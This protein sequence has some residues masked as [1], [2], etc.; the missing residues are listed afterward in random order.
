MT[1]TDRFRADLDALAAPGARLGIALSGGPDSLALLLLAAAAR[2]GAVEAA[3]VDH[4]LRTDS[5]AEAEAAAAICA[6][7]GIPHV[8]LTIDWPERPITALQERARGERYRLLAGWAE[9]RGL[10]AIL[11][12]HHA[13][14]QAET[15]LMRLNRG[16]GVRGLGGM[17]P[18]SP[19]PQVRHPRERG[20]PPVLL[21]PLLGWRRAE[22]ERICADANLT[23][24]TDPS[25]AD[26]RFERVRIR[27]ALSDAGWIDSSA[28]AT[29]AAHLASADQALDWA[30]DREWR[31]AVSEENGRITYMPSDAPA[32]I[33]RRLVAR[34]ITALT[35]EGSAEPLRARELDPLLAMLRSGGQATLRGV[36][37]SGGPQWRFS[38]APERRH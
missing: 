32:E 8:I 24:N 20:D 11:T 25:N 12:G 38:P 13:D 4:A 6:R 26:D 36:L 3:T 7:L 21:R 14:D 31:G 33:V 2:P 15:L 17:R 16:A 37:C 5:R 1:T 27:K 35:R 19:I 30:T 9:E 34:A 18:T 10:D 23:P 29:S 22:L 28:L